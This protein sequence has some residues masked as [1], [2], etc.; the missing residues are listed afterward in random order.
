VTS[1]EPDAREGVLVFNNSP[2]SHFA[3]AGELD[4]LALLVEGY[5]CVTT[6]AV[7]QELERG[8]VADARIGQVLQLPW[9]GVVAADDLEVLYVLAVY[10]DR[11]GNR[12]RNAGE[13]SVLAWAEVHGAVAYVDD[14]VACNVARQRKVAVRR[15]LE[16]IVSGY[17][18][19]VLTEDRAQGLVSALVQE[20]A[21][22]PQGAHQD[23]FGWARAQGLL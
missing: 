12:Q 17:R 19:D 5:R 20:D 7:Q 6:R 1:D 4:A 21:R 11:L 22:L 8:A 18:R 2:L 16:L 10:M 23:L 15:T 3:R 9:L 14:Q 13:A